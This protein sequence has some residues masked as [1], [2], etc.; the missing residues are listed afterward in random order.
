MADGEL[1]GARREIFHDALLLAIV[2]VGVSTVD[3]VVLSVALEFGLTR[4]VRSRGLLVLDL[5]L[6]GS[7]L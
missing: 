3:L 7:E 5:D 4:G 2:E 6:I 1:V